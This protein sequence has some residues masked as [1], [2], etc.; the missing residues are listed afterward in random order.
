MSALAAPTKNILVYGDSLSAGFGIAREQSWPSLLGQKLAA[1][2]SRYTVVNASIS[3]ETT[4][5]GLVRFA[6]TIQDH[7]P[8]IVIIELGAN[9]GLRGLPLTAMRAN[10]LAMIRAAKQSRAS[11]LL[12]GMKIPPNYGIDYTAQFAQSFIA[13][14][15]HEKIAC[16]HFLLEPIA[17]QR[18]AFQADGMHPVAAAQPKLLAHMWSALQPLLKEK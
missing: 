16:L 10:L 12:I 2:R 17:N 15:A 1:S 14:A 13:I 18:E 3:G 4:S 5:G 8:A 9:D 7:R 11:V 6:R